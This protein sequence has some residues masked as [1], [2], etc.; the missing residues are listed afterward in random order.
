MAGIS[1]RLTDL[2]PTGMRCETAARLD[3]DD[4]VK[5]AS[6]GFDAV[7]S[8]AHCQREGGTTLAGLRFLTVRFQLATGNFQS[9][10]V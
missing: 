10:K 8:V 6:P 1:G 4:V 3:P 2:S 5:V 9:I 7:G